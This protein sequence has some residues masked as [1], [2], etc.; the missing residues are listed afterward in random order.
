VD[1]RVGVGVVV[2]VN[3]VEVPDLRIDN[4]CER[5]ESRSDKVGRIERESA[6]PRLSARVEN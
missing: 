2:E 5:D 6:L 4:Q 3:K 1:V